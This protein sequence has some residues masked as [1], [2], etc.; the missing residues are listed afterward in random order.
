MIIAKSG[1]KCHQTPR[2]MVVRNLPF[3]AKSLADS[4][5]TAV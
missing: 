5:L 3:F 2:S 4:E 1:A